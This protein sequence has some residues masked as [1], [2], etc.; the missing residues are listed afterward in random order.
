MA[1]LYLKIIEA[2]AIFSEICA[3]A[4]QSFKCYRHI[5]FISN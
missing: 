2:A 5:T 4:Q 3:H 1:F